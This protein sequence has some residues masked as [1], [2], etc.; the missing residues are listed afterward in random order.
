LTRNILLPLGS[1]RGQRHGMRGNCAIFLESITF[2]HA[3]GNNDATTWN[4]P[5]RARHHLGDC[6]SA[7]ANWWARQDSNLQPSGYE[8]LALTIEL[9]ALRRAHPIIAMREI[10]IAGVRKR[11]I[12]LEHTRATALLNF[13]TACSRRSRR[14]SRVG[15][16][17]ASRSADHP[18]IASIQREAQ[19]DF[20][21]C[22]ATAGCCPV[23]CRAQRQ[24]VRKDGSSPAPAALLQCNITP[25]PRREQTRYDPRWGPYRT[26]V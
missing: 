1:L 8:P 21:R 25:P 15:A 18:V 26:F 5:S 6:P 22:A 19:R 9:R 24:A 20:A 3:Q 11:R 14:A 17:P 12:G 2:D 10:G 13:Q 4:F 16:T 23:H 7:W